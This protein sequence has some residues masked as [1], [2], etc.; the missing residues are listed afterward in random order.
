MKRDPRLEPLSRDHHHA[1]VLARALRWAARGH[2][3]A[4]RD[5]LALLRRAWTEVLEI[6]FREEEEW[7]APLMEAGEAERLASDHA[8]LRRL[9]ADLLE[10]RRDERCLVAFSSLLHAHIRWEERVLF[11]RL[12]SDAPS[13]ALDEVGRRLATSV[14]RP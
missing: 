9:C 1:L 14:R 4:P 2:A 8:E 6:H 11:P 3:R 7:L 12:E 10:G 13:G 5:P